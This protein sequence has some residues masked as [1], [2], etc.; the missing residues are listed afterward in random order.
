MTE[1]ST[2]LEALSR[3]DV[4]KGAAILSFTVALSLPAIAEGKKKVIG[5]LAAGPWNDYGY[6]QSHFDAMEEL[7]KNQDVK[8]TKEEGVPETADVQKSI[9]SMIEIDGA[10]IIVGTAYGYFDPHM[11]EM[12]KRYPDVKFLHCGGY[13]KEGMPENLSSYFAYSDEVAYIAGVVAGKM[14]AGKPIGYVASKPIAGVLAAVNAFALGARSI[15][16]AATVELV[17]TGEWSDPVKEANATNSLIDKGVVVLACDVDAPKVVIDTCEQRGVLCV[18]RHT[19]L[20]ALAPKTFLTGTEWHWIAVYNAALEGKAIDHN[21]RGGLAQ[22]MVRMSPYGEAAS[23]Q[24]RDAADAV[25]ASLLA[26]TSNVYVGPIKD[27]TG[28]ERIAVGVTLPITDPS[29][30]LVDWLVEGIKGSA[31]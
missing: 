14:A 2:S 11:I 28:K 15:D 17:L 1:I 7:A 16:G 25:K 26:G 30:E 10:S 20:S 21:L 9:R 6:T 3:R 29:W 4:L 24:A 23:Q 19:N 8:I 31:S 18:G 22:N 12:A 13:W 5:F 27:N